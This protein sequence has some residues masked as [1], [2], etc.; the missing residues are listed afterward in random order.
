MRT[1]RVVLIEIQ[2]GNVIEVD[3]VV[4]CF[5]GDRL[6]FVVVNNDIVAGVGTEHFVWVDG[7][8]IIQRQDKG[9]AMPPPTNPLQDGKL[10]CKVKVGEVD[11]IKHVVRIKAD[12]G[13]AG[14]PYTTYKYT[15]KSGVGSVADPHP[16]KLDPDIDVVTP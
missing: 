14:I 2:P 7:G 9:M 1:T 6:V 16:A 10:W 11:R 5:P 12:F 15:V 8:E 3:D 4:R 13:N